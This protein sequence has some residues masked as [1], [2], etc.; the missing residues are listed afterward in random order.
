ME[1]SVKIPLID[2][3]L[4]VDEQEQFEKVEESEKVHRR[5]LALETGDKSV[6]P[7]ESRV[8]P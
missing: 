5:R 1:H 7:S 4:P 3:V 8:I 6:D 2:D